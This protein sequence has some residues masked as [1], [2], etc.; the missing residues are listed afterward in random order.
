VKRSKA[1]CLAVELVVW[2]GWSIANAEKIP[3]PEAL[4]Q[5]SARPVTLSVIEPH[6][7]TPEHLV[8]VDYLAFPA[9]V[10]ISAAL[11]PE[12]EAKT[13]TIEFRALDGYV[14]RIDVRRLANG[15]AYMAF[16]R[17]D[18]SPFTVD[19][20]AQNEK[21]VP[22][23]PYYLVWDNRGDPDLLSE[24]ARNWPYQVIDVSLFN[25]SE[26]A[27]RPPGFDPVLEPGLSSAKANCLT[28]HQVNGFG[29]GKV[30]GNL[31]LV[32][33]AMPVAEFVK[34]TLEPSSVKPDTAMPALSANLDEA[35]RRAIAQS[36]YE[37]LSH[38]PI[39][40]TPKS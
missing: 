5:L 34:W 37:Y 10:V 17:A 20:L 19:N 40:P 7:S 35:Q 26:A 23:G 27:L 13:K 1:C 4:E 25:V 3:S 38:V 30:E 18:R 29:G 22:L 12:W 9:P 2:P 21:N 32:A 15:K 14:S 39:T 28:C 6:L 36:I 16:A 24:G 31:A 8:A 33:R 11:G